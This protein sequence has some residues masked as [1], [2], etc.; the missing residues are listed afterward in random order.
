MRRFQKQSIETGVTLAD[1][2][3]L[4]LDDTKSGLKKLDDKHSFTG[5][6]KKTG[7]TIAALAQQVDKRHDISGK[8][9]VAMQA[10]TAATLQ[11][12]ES[13]QRIAEESGLKRHLGTHRRCNQN[14]FG[15]P[16][17]AVGQAA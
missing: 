7:D 8:A 17:G 14:S 2:A 10:V 15:R 6:L 11:T 3:S 12:K 5:K 1:K 13:T 9:G 16:C 4:A